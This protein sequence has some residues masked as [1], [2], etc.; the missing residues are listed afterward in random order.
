MLVD[1]PLP[2]PLA[3]ALPLFI[4]VVNLGSGMESLAASTKV[5]SSGNGPNVL[6]DT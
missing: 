2:L 6:W 4:A 1:L 5:D 3:I